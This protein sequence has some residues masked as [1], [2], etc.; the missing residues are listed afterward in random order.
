MLVNFAFLVPQAIMKGLANAVLC[1]SSTR[2]V[3]QICV[4][5]IHAEVM[6]MEAT[7]LRQAEPQ[8]HGDP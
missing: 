8:S 6:D 7:D 4:P 3:S 2:I 1:E 5:L